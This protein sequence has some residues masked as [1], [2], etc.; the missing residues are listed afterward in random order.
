MLKPRTMLVVSLIAAAAASRLLPHPPNLTSVTAIALFGGAMLADWR[1]AFLVPLA[2][3]F[4]TDLVLGFHDQMPV[5]YGSFALI[6]CLG[7]WLQR[8]RSAATIAGAAI[9]SALLFFLT[10]NFGVWALDGMY[11]HTEAGLIACY[12]AAL[13]FLRNMLEGDL[14]YTFVLFAG[15]ALAERRFPALRPLVAIPAQA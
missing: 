2:A 5:V 13:P 7:L 10:T 1:L 3:L 4:A 9:V 15:V 12:T 11:P 6:V 14:L 8:R